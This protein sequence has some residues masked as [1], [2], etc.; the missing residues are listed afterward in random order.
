MKLEISL[1]TCIFTPQSLP[2][3]TAMHL[4]IQ[5]MSTTLIT[6]SLHSKVSHNVSVFDGSACL[7]SL[8]NSIQF[9]QVKGEISMQFCTLISIEQAAL[10]QCP[11]DTTTIESVSTEL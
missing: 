3:I 5:H 9:M 7:S 1:F 11:G 6:E 2:L 4:T 10:L 8:T